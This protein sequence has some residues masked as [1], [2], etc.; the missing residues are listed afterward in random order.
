MSLRLHDLCACQV[1][2]ILD[3]IA[4][5]SAVFLALALSIYYVL[6][7]MI[8]RR[9]RLKVHTGRVLFVIAHPDDECMFF[10]PTILALTRSGQYDV[11][12]LC[13]SS[14]LVLTDVSSVMS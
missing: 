14:G 1:M 11:F 9:V 2:Y 7:R 4:V 10:A 5:I 3:W 8:R 12:L 6:R 13:L